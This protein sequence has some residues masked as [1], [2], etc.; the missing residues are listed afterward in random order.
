[1]NP[2]SASTF[3]RRHKRHAAML[4]GL[5]IVVTLGL[6]STVALM[7]AA[8]VEPGRLAYMAYS[9]FSLITPQSTQSGPDPA[10]FARLQANS[11]VAK[12]LPSTFIRI[13]LRGMVPGQGFQFDLL[14]AAENDVPYNMG[15]GK[16][17]IRRLCCDQWSQTQRGYS[18]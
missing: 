5:S 7:W 6:Y 18:L 11:D 2:L 8:L 12:I 4:L 15:D 3:Y 13:Q 16:S 1:M 9:K 14:G 17:P 10:L